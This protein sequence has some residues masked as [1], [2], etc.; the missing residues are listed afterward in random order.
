MAD[1]FYKVNAYTIFKRIAVLPVSSGQHRKKES[2]SITDSNQMKYRIL[3]MQPNE[4][5]TTRDTETR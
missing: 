4:N 1:V 3:K 2:G 5:E